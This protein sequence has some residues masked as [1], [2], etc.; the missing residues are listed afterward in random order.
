MDANS[1]PLSSASN[2][3]PKMWLNPKLYRTRLLLDVLRIFILPCVI[4]SYLCRDFGIKLGFLRIVAF[5][6]AIV[7][8]GFLNNI[9][10]DIRS[11]IEAKRMGAKP[12]KRIRG[13]WPGNIDI[14]FRMMKAFKTAYIMDVYLELFQEYQCTTLNTRILWVDQVR[15]LSQSYYSLVYPLLIKI[16]TMDEEHIKFVHATGFNHFWRGRRQKERMWASWFA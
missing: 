11:T 8:W 14:L 4:L 15:Y 7:F 1:G 16:I 10:H 5:P 6:F 2:Q 13:R 12:I 9:W 3:A